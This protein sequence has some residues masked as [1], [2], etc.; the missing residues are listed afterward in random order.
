M[1]IQA[2]TLWYT[3]EKE[4][5][6]SKFDTKLLLNLIHVLV[7]KNEMKGNFLTLNICGIY[8]NIEQV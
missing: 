7:T 6:V 4:V 5:V 8:F 1:Y 3:E 2:N